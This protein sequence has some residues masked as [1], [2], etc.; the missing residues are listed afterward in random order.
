MEKI[1]IKNIG[2]IKN[3]EINL[4]KVNVFIGPQSSGKSTIAKLVSFCQWLEKYI[5][6]NQGTATIDGD[7]FKTQLI[8]FHGFNKFFGDDSFLGYDSDL[9]KLEYHTA[10]NF[11]IKIIGDLQN[12]VMKKIAY[13]P[14]ERNVLSL[15][16]ISS[17][18]MENNYIRGFIFDWLSIRNKYNKDNRYPILNLGVDYYYDSSKGDVITLE[19]GKELS[20]SESSSGLQAIIPMLVYVNYITKWI[21]END[22]DVSFDRYTSL[23]RAVLKDVTQGNED[24]K[25]I[26]L[27]LKEPKIRESINTL[28]KQ[29]AKWSS[30]GRLESSSLNDLIDRIGRPHCTKLSIEEGEMNIFPSTQYELVKKIFAAMDFNRGDTLLLTTHSPYI[31]TSINNLIEASNAVNENEK[32]KEAKEKVIPSDSWINYTDVNAW[33]V[34]NGTVSSIND[35]EDEMIS[36]EALDKASEVIS[37]DFE[38]LLYS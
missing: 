29:I 30:Q 16:G 28:I 10:E 12:G 19:N 6:I 20:L 32:V 23:Q 31:V 11:Q 22:A 25:N 2:P 15:P 38:K 13:I 9:I 37:S 14:S 7:F 26:E 36:T 1:E 21:Y 17:L 5:V 4:N 3:A 27:A 8:S 34:Y 35:D 18:Q 33:A 24:D